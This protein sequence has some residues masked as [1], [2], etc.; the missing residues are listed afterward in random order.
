MNMDDVSLGLMG[1]TADAVRTFAFLQRKL[2]DI[3]LVVNLAKTA[4]LPPEGPS[5][6]TEHISLLESVAVRIAD[7]GGVTAVGVPIGTD[8]YMQ[9]RA[10]DM[11]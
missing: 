3:G 5:P 1:V 7:E 8:E 6:T 10:M 4:A 2:D 11:Q 9:Q